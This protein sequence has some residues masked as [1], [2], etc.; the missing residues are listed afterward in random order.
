MKRT[1]QPPA[2]AEVELEP[3]LRTV[4]H[5]RDHGLEPVVPADVAWKLYGLYGL[6]VSGRVELWERA[7]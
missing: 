3:W 7:A 5:L 2:S 4:L 1:R 6:R